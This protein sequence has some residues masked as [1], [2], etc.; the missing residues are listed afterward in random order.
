M[1]PSDQKVIMG[2]FCSVPAGFGFSFHAD[3]GALF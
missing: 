1:F 3:D 2:F